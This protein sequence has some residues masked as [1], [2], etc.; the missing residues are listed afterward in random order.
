MKYIHKL[1]IRALLILIIPLNILLY[2]IKPVTIY[3]IYYI[4]YLLNYNPKLSFDALIIN[5]YNL[6]FASACIAI[7]AYHLLALLILFTKDIKLKDGIKY[8]LFGSFLILFVNILRII[9]L[10]LVGINYGEKWFELI[11]LTFWYGVSGVY[12]ALVWILMIYLFKIKNIP[13]YTDIKYLYKKSVFNNRNKFI[14]KH[15]GKR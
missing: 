14:S 11:H 2:I 7:S 4:F 6:I 8:F 9:V 5:S 10:I 12:V 1:I 3:P 15:K 13:I